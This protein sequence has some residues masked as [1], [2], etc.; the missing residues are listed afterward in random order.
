M[1]RIRTGDVV[2]IRLKGGGHM[3]R[4]WA[5]VM[6]ANAENQILKV[7]LD[8]KPV[9]PMFSKGEELEIPIDYVFAKYAH[10]TPMKEE[11]EK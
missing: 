6:E 5:I 10:P 1:E 2:K 8:N 9:N 3:E 7:K 11:E 4:I